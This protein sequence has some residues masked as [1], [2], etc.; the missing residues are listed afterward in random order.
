MIYNSWQFNYVKA[1]GF[2]NTEIEWVIDMNLQSLYQINPEQ[3]VLLKSCDIVAI[4][5][6]LGGSQVAYTPILSRLIGDFNQSFN[7]VATLATL[8]LPNPTFVITQ[9]AG[10]TF[11]D[12]GPFIAPKNAQI[13]MPATFQLAFQT[14]TLPQAVAGDDIRVWFTL[15]YDIEPKKRF[16]QVG[17]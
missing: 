13:L 3:L 15:G 9:F 7:I 6:D 4:R 11:S 14:G 12:V 2:A 1:A 8:P 16:N 17:Q 10:I 5:H